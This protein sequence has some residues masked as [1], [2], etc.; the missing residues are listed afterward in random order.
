[1][2]ALHMTSRQHKIAGISIPDTD[3]LSV[4]VLKKYL[5]AGA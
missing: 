4:L 3:L 2:Q 1:M 5:P